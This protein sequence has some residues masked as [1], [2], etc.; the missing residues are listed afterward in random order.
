MKDFK[1]EVQVNKEHYSFGHEVSFLNVY[2]QIDDVL[3]LVKQRNIENPKILVIGVGDHLLDIILKYKFGF[4]VKTFDVDSALEPNFVGSV[5]KVDSAVHEYFDIVVCAHVLEHLPYE[6][7]N[8]SLQ[9]IRAISDYAI[10]YLPIAQFG[11]RLKFEIFPIIAKQINFLCT[12]FFKKHSFDGQHYWEIGTR[13]YS[14]PFVRNKINNFFKIEK[15]Y[16]AKNWL[17]SYNFVLK[18]KK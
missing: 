15:E 7:F 6:Y 17:Y 14:L 10:I 11:L 5:D 13:G 4:H 3:F 1:A 8:Q 16:N 9:K 2:N 18:S 12:W